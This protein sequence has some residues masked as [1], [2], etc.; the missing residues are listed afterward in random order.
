M[1]RGREDL[2]FMIA[3][4]RSKSITCDDGRDGA[5]IGAALSN[6]VGSGLGAVAALPD[7]A[8]EVFHGLKHLN[9]FS[10]S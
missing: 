8:N 1:S 7:G 3:A 6:L 9:N 4:C 10:P 5:Q 2:S